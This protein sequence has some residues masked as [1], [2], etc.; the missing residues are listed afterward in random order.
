M[1]RRADGT[2]HGTHYDKRCEKCD[3]PFRTRK[4]ESRYCGPR[5]GNLARYDRIGRVAAED[6]APKRS[7]CRECGTVFEG[8]RKY[9]TAECRA[10]GISRAPKPQRGPLRTAIEASDFAALSQHLATRC[11]LADNG[12][13]VWNGALNDGYPVTQFGKR[14]VQLHRA[15]LEVKHGGPLGSQAAHHV[16]AN[17]R[18]VNPDHLQPVTH[19][20][21]IAEMLARRAYIARIAELEEALRG[22]DPHHPLLGHVRVA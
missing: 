1:S 13:W 11:T 3:S 5:C 6:R 19:R 7:T 22:A 14:T 20:D 21:N 16:C 2:L 9:C 17:S 18:C 4:P 12:C 15:V 8:E 10:V